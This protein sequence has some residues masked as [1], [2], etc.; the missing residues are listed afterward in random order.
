MTPL[1]V[2]LYFAVSLGVAFTAGPGT[3]FAFLYLPAVLLLHSVSGIEL[4]TVP[5][6]TPT[7]AATYAILLSLLPRLGR[8]IGFRLHLIDAAVIALSAAAIASEIKTDPGSNGVNQLVIQIVF[9]L[10]PYFFARAH[11]GSL[12]F[13]RQCLKSIVASLLILLPFTLIETRL[14]PQFYVQTLDR[15]GLDA[16]SLG[17]PYHRF[18][19]FRAETSFQHPIYMGDACLVLLGFIG[20]LA[21]TTPSRHRRF[22]F[23]LA[24]A[25]ALAGIVFALSIGPLISLGIAI[26]LFFGL[27]S[28]RLTRPLLPIAVFAAILVGFLFMHRLAREELGDRPEGAVESSAWVRQRIVKDS[29]ELAANAGPWGLGREIDPAVLPVESVDNAYLLFAMCRG[30]VFT[31]I[32]LALPVLAAWRIG[33][34]LL[35]ETPGQQHLFPIAAAASA[36]LAMSFAFFGVWAGWQG[37]TYTVLWLALVGSTMTAADAAIAASAPAVQVRAQPIHPLAGGA[38]A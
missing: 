11:F 2:I 14:W 8:P 15:L 16:H 3:C 32:W 29:W 23:R 30:W 17:F 9:W 4:P 10:F 24:I 25:S 22:G 34:S 5:A 26:A 38:L 21:A 33:R 37:E 7:T 27:R 35:A 31:A 19:L 1:F 13:R 28:I 6:L 18:G 20:L 36:V 12:T